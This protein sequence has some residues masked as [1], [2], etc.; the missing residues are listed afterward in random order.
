MTKDK[1]DQTFII[2]NQSSYFLHPSDSPGT[3]ITAIKFDGKNY[4][5]G[6]KVVITSLRSKNKLGFIDG[7]ITK[8]TEKEGEEA[9]AWEMVNSMVLSWIMNVIDPRLHKSVAYVD[10]A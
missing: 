9:K 4:D 1:K 7:S 2:T 5:L 6:G 3:V 10:T 8:P